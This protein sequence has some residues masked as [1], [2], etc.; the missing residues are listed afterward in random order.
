METTEE[1]YSLNRGIV[2]VL[3]LIA[4]AGAAGLYLIKS[5]S[6]ILVKAPKDERIAFVSDRDGHSNVWTMKSDGNEASQV[7]RDAAIEETPQ[8]S[9]DGRE[10]A[11]T[12]DKYD[13]R[14]E[15]CISSWNGRHD[16]R[17]T[18]STGVK[19]QP[20][21]SNDGNMMNYLSNAKVYSVPVQ[22]GE[23]EQYIPPHESPQITGQN[24]VFAPCKYAA[25]SPSQRN[26]VLLVQEIDAER[27]AVIAEMGA[28]PPESP[29]DLKM[30]KLIGG[31][32]LDAA[33]SPSGKEVA[34]A[35]VSASGKNGLGVLDL[36]N[37]RARI[38]FSSKEKNSG[39]AKPVWSPD[40]RSIAFEVWE[41]QDGVPLVSKGI[42]IVSAAGGNAKLAVAGEAEGACWSPD[43][44]YI[45]CSL[46]MG[47]G[48]RDIVRLN[49]D[50]TG[51]INLTNGKGDSYSPSWSPIPA[52]R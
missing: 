5:G 7:T 23:E 17:L 19:E 32:S 18:R 38:I 10:I 14:F 45:A 25:W 2:A 4:L 43:G 51:M 41:M 22:G 50:G 49:A 6:G 24:G 47:N 28:M 40:G 26:A 35:F 48:K 16:R 46:R 33:W 3:I 39:P 27:V 11:Y 42:H 8:W 52:A 31:R 36:T 1:G 15:V 44:R 21:W 20:V 29:E 30:V 12:S 37:G 34:A 9:P 13:E